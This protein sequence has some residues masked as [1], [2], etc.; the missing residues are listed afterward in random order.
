MPG[1]LM[2]ECCLHTLRVYLLRMGWVMEAEGKAVEPVP[3][4]ISQLKCRGQ[5]IRSTK[6]AA[7]EITLKE[8]GYRPEP[9]AVVDAM[10]YGDGKKIVEITSMSVRFAG[11]TREEVE[12]H[13]LGFSDV[14]EAAACMVE[15]NGVLY[16]RKPPLFTYEQINAFAV[17]K[18]SFAFGA[19]Y[20]VFDKDRKIARLPGPPYQFM[21]R[22][23]HIQDCEPWVLTAGGVIEAQYDVPPEEWYFGSNRQGDMPFAVLLEIALQP[24]GWLAGYLGSALTSEEDLS[25]RNL[26]GTAT[27]FMAV[28]PDVGTLSIDVKITRVSNAGGMIIQNFDYK[29]RS[30]QGL[31]YEGDTYFGF[32]SKSALANQVG[33]REAQPWKPSERDLEAA[34]SFVYPKE[35]SYPTGMIRMVDEV[36]AF[37]PDGGPCGLGFIRGMKAVN[38][39]EW[40]FKAH[41][42]QD[43]VIPGSLGLESFLQLLKV[44]AARRWGWSAGSRIEAVACG[45]KHEWLY[46]GQIIPSDSMVTVEAVVTR[47]DDETRTL[48]ADGFLTVD[49]RIIY[50]MKDF[51]VRLLGA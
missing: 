18:P 51:P 32:F 3:G 11:A 26:G 40:F 44:V 15:E 6:V 41:F 24:C 35:G 5:V 4:V 46:R 1:T 29:V 22:V 47:V 37:L 45:G 28:G 30:R 9:Y 50:G 13:W 21:D 2:F 31:V 14:P 20:E 12:S 10:M 36:T 23:T 16:E 39:D 43:P 48:Y 19:R 38:P 25:F 49:G 33:I 17:G 27:Q 42:Y 7:Y 8:L 34:E